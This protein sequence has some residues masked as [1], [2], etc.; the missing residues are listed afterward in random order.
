MP[1]IVELLEDL[2]SFKYYSGKGSTSTIGDF[3]QKEMKYGNDVLGG[4]TSEQSNFQNDLFY[5]PIPTDITPFGQDV[6][7][8]GGA[9][10]PLRTENDLKRFENFIT[11]PKGMFFIAKQEILSRQQAKLPGTI[12]PTR[13]YNPVQTGLQV[14][15][16]AVGLHVVGKGLGEVGNT[17][18]TFAADVIKGK[19]PFEK[20]DSIDPTNR[21]LYQTKLSNE[22]GYNVFN[23][24]QS[25]TTNRLGLLFQSKMLSDV[26]EEGDSEKTAFGQF[27]T[28]QKEG[29]T[30][31][32]KGM[33]NPSIY[34]K[35]GIDEHNPQILLK[36]DG[37]PNATV[38]GVTNSVYKRVVDTTLEGQNKAGA[39][40]KWKDQWVTLTSNQ[41]FDFPRNTN[42]TIY[43]D[44]RAE[45]KASDITKPSPDTP[46]A[47]FLASSDYGK[48][49]R[50]TYMQGD[51]GSSQID[52][53]NFVKGGGSTGR[54]EVNWTE[55]N[56]M[57]ST[58][59][60]E[61]QDLIDFYI[62][63]IDND[64]IANNSYIRFRAFLG[65]ISD[66]YNATWN[67]HRFMGRG[68]NF[69]TYGGFNRAINLSFQVHAQS[70]KELNR[71]YTKLNYLAS[72]CA[73]D[74]S[75]TTGF[76][77]GNLIK[78]TIGD[79]LNEVPGILTSLNYNIND[80]YPWDIG[81]DEEG[82]KTD[83]AL[84]MLIDVSGFQF[85][86]IPE[87]LPSKVKNSWVQTQI[88]ENM[89]SPFISLGK[90]HK[91]YNT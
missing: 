23:Q 61:Q 60:D 50:K 70:K 41:I 63:A 88:S 14:G 76:M 87:T 11:S 59:N 9:S 54:D 38:P 74:Y 24:E 12:K 85:T 44:F 55:V 28:R 77:R 33:I 4:G 49:N 73:P 29:F 79:Y 25:Q 22:D 48:W 20:S 3:G 1:S 58:V 45:I 6:I 89:N 90:D 84:P 35:F 21:Y 17:L 65:Q 40:G 67:Q 37:G 36:Y 7:I 15:G 78:L 26:P 16:N 32:V 80:N 62:V 10:L 56:N 53:T 39:Q 19:N 27:L 30:N 52:R 43:G 71:M 5:P 18:T 42:S 8:R 81:R 13:L 75:A 57:G 83:L 2:S 68:E 34:Q 46:A 86:P 47:K 31:F 91:G 64:N 82:I 72:L 51:P 66:N 69:Y